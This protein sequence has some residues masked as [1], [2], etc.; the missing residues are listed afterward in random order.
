[1]LL[2]HFS[3]GLL[4][5]NFLASGGSSGGGSRLGFIEGV[6]E[7]EAAVLVLPEAT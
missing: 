2:L 6:E 4:L 1:M 7:S 3:S 5:G